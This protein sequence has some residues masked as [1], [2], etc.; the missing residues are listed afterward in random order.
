MIDNDETAGPAER[1]PTLIA[2]PGTPL[3][4]GRDAAAI[5][6]LRLVG[7]PICAGGDASRR[8]GPPSRKLTADEVKRFFPGIAARA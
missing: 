7:H 4:V 6:A 8:S 1:E 5:M 3:M 2:L